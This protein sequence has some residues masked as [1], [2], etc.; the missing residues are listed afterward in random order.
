MGYALKR[1][2]ACYLTVELPNGSELDLGLPVNLEDWE[3][4]DFKVHVLED[5][6]IVGY[7]THD[8]NCSNPLEDDCYLGSIY[9]HPKHRYGGHDEDVDYY[10]AL[11]RDRYGEPRIDEDKVQALWEEKVQALPDEVFAPFYPEGETSASLKAFYERCKL[12]LATEEAGDWGL[13]AM[14]RAAFFHNIKVG[15]WE[16]EAEEC[17]KLEELIEPHLTWDWSEVAEACAEPGDPCA[18]VL[19]IYEHSGVSYSISGQGM[20]CRWDTSTG[21]AVW[22]PS[23]EG[24]EEIERRGA[25]YD[26]A[27]IEETPLTRGRNLKYRILVDGKTVAHS[28]DWGKLWGIAQ[29]IARLRITAGVAPCRNG[30]ALAAEQLAE[31]TC[32][33][34]TAWCNGDCYG[35]VTAVFDYNGDLL[36]EDD[37]WGYVG[38][39]WAEEELESRV[40]A[41][42]EENSK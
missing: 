27:Y 21:A 35:V 30:R 32:E 24:L 26:H 1:R 34:Y 23:A 28:D 25:V 38:S 36:E 13:R 39:E 40:A 4:P 3:A 17:E 10:N 15:D 2:A 6:I 5:K 41:L 18:V 7:I 20:Q 12:Q 42:V 37:C 29:D 19:D 9:H 22:L 14:V 16:F 31:R 8:D 11:G 33:T